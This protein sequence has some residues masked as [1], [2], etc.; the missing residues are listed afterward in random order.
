M[1]KR[2]K[3][4]SIRCSVN[5]QPNKSEKKGYYRHGDAALLATDF[6]NIS[7]PKNS[8]ASLLLPCGAA[9][10]IEREKSQAK[11]RPENAHNEERHMK[12]VHHINLHDDI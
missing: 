12:G 8:D 3:S 10:P 4:E 9:E 1:P 11:Q 5:N 6:H 2:A 7:N